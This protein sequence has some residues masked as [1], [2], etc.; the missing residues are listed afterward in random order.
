MKGF[1]EQQLWYKW[2]LY[3]IVDNMRSR[4]DK[5]DAKATQQLA[6]QAG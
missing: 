3:C 1:V 5:L 2:S 4:K 6:H